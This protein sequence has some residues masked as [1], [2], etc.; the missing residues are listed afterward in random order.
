MFERL[1]FAS[2]SLISP[3]LRSASIA[4]CLPGI[5]SNVKRAATSDTR[6]EPLVITIKFTKTMIMN[7]RN[8]TIASPPITKLP[9]AFII[10]LMF[11][12]PPPE[13]IERVVEMFSDKR[14]T[15]DISNIVGKTENSNA[16]L[17]NI[18]ITRMIS[19]SAMLSIIRKSC[20]GTGSGMIIARTMNMINK[21]IE[22]LSILRT[23][24]P[25]P[26]L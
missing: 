11:P 1:F 22:L 18:V 19:E 14:N 7:I 4:I 16:L 3:E 24:F 6:S 12:A 10:L 9:N 20:T 25:L 17:I 13:R 2:S 26:F 15:V 8:P 5:A 21:T 23:K